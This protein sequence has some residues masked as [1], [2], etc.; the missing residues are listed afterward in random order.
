MLVLNTM[1]DFL[2]SQENEK[3]IVHLAL[4]GGLHHTC[5]FLVEEKLRRNIQSF[6]LGFFAASKSSP[7][8]REGNA[9]SP[10][11]GYVIPLEVL[12]L[13]MSMFV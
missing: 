4:E 12:C 11:S 5:E 8:G 9:G 1:G 6:C 10:P 2:P 13:H 3:L 7:N